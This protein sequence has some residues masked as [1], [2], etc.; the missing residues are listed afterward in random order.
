MLEAFTADIMIITA[1]DIKESGVSLMCDKGES[2]SS[3]ET[4]KNAPH[5]KLLAYYNKV[6]Q[7]VCVLNFGSNT[8]GNTSEDAAKD[9]DHA[10]KI[11]DHII[12][13]RILFSAQCTDA[14][15]GGTRTSLRD[16]LLKLG[17][18]SENDIQNYYCTTCTL[19]ALN[20]T[21]SVPIENCLGS[22]GVGSR[23]IMQA[24]F[25]CY[26][27][28]QKY[29]TKEWKEK[30]EVSTGNKCTKQIAKPV[31]SRWE[32]VGEGAQHLKGNLPDWKKMAV[33]ILKDEATG[34]ERYLIAKDLADLLDEN[35][36]IAHLYLLCGYDDAF[37]SI[38]FNFLKSLDPTTGTPGFLSIHMALHL[39]VI[40]RDLLHLSVHWKESTYFKEFVRKYK[41][42]NNPP[43]TIDIC[44]THFFRLVIE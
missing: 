1:Y 19:H 13:G 4:K 24:L 42:I 8:T 38:H 9:I 3:N 6:R 37:F 40:H 33:S 15:G 23:T 35:M 26:N 27:L 14:G 10:L 29:E 34:N 18:I 7:K 25:L 2:R 11:W 31:L 5:V 20:L 28:T 30:W 17:R 32:H 41:E 12:E 36:I 21:L 44:M 22:G 39:Y 16:W 43:Y